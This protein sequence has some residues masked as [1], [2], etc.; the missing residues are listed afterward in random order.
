M[1]GSKVLGLVAIIAL[2][3]VAMAQDGSTRRASQQELVPRAEQAG[4]VFVPQTDKAPSG[5]AHTT[6]LLRSIDGIKPTVLPTLEGVNPEVSYEQT[7][8]TPN[9][10]GCIYVKSPT[11][12]GCV[13][14]VNG[15]G[16]SAAGYG[17]IA[18]VDAYDNPDAAS[19]VTTFNAQ[20]PLAAT[21]FTKIYANG[22]GACTKPAA[23]AGWA[24]EES[25]DIEWAHV[26]APNAAIILVEAC[27]NSNAN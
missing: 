7:T 21:S 26:F 5:F 15:G 8:E 10:M 16:P 24:L 27:T 11:S 13:P 14:N 6:Y 4:K 9:S 17:A 20:W 1:K 3:A 19:D 12:A 23:N 2:G 25:L 22:N 18:I